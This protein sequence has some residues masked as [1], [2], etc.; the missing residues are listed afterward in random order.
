MDIIKQAY[1]KKQPKTKTLYFCPNCGSTN[2]QFK[3][4]VNANTGTCTDGHI[5]NEKDD[6]YC[7]DCESHIEL[8][9]FEFKPDAH[10][11]GYQ[12]VGK[13]NTCDEGSLH[14]DIE[15]SRNVYCL[16][17]ANIMLE[18]ADTF[19]T[20]EFRLKAIWKDEIEEPIMMYLGSNPR[21]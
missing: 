14:P 5:S 16:S 2:V 17:Q 15:D 20:G 7:L 4:W 9:K 8:N 12:V 21:E 10:V 11:I 18:L 13:D 1:R 6:N 19:D 3:S